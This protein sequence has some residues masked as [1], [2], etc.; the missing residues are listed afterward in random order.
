MVAA[1]DMKLK[2]KIL[3]AIELYLNKVHYVFRRII[4]FEIY[5]VTYQISAEKGKRCEKYCNN[6]I[7]KYAMSNKKSVPSLKKF[8]AKNKFKE[9]IFKKI[10]VYEKYYDLKCKRTFR[11]RRI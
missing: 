1:A 5:E 7:V 4:G 11:F 2:R 10:G 6:R 9:R 8:I 3:K